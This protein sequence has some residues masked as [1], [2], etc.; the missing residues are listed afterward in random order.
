GA[1]P[2]NFMRHYYDVYCLLQDTE[3]LEFFGT[4]EYAAHKERRF[5]RADNQVI[6]DNEAFLLSDPE[7]RATYKAAYQATHA[8]YYHS[9][10]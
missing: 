7:T 3:T 1:F 6:A 9:Q 4:P 10:P 5:R 8:L 2:V